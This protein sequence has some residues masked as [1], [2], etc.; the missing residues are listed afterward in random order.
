MGSPDTSCHSATTMQPVYPR[1]LEIPTFINPRSMEK[2]AKAAQL[3]IFY[4]GQVVVFDDF[5][6]DEV[7]E[8]M[9]LAL[10]TKGISQ[11]QNSSAYAQTHNQQ[12]NNHPSSIPNII[13]QAPPTPIVN[14]TFLLILR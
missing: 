11:S 1:H 5:P 7:H 13:P 6:A 8:V 10:A 12:G 3:T 2:E 9:S 14:G 4:D